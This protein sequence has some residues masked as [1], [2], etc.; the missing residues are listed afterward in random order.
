MPFAFVAALAALAPVT[1]PAPAAPAPLILDRGRVDRAPLVPADSAPAGPPGG[2]TAIEARANGVTIQR[3]LFDHGAVP[4]PVAAAAQRF[5]GQSATGETL[6]A[7]GKAMADAYARSDIAL[8]SV[9]VPRQSFARGEVHILAIEGFIERATFV[10]GETRLLRAYARALAAER[11][12]RRRTL[13]RYVSLM[14]DVPGG[15]IDVQLLRGTK[16]GGVVLQI[17]ATRKHREAA[18][19]FDNQGPSLL[20]DA[21]MRGELHAYSLLRDGDRTDLTGLA[22]PDFHHLLYVAGAHATPLGDEGATITA[23][24][25]YIVT[26]PRHSLIEGHA[27]TFGVTAS[28]PLIRGYRRNLTASIGLDGVDSDAAAFGTSLSSDRT[29]ALRG[30]LGYA[31]SGTKAA[32]TAG[33]TISRGLDILGA[34]GTANATDTVFTKVNGRVTYDRQVAARWFVHLRA[35]GQYSA[36]RLA[37]AERFAVGGADFGRAFDSALLSGDRGA[38]GSAELAWRPKLPTRLAGSEVYGF[39]DGARL[40]IAARYP[41]AAGTFG[42]AS[43]GGGVRLA[44][45]NRAS[46]QIEGA[47]AIDQPYSGY[48]AGWR[49]NIGWRLSLAHH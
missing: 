9:V 17:A 47:S 13:E 38:A 45:G 30:A 49:V 15:K 6:A 37:A 5:V 10:K 32:F 23:S 18:L 31:M 8:Y 3:I 26:R 27:T 33:L 16:P 28:W 24:A 46:I 4:A 34:R 22:S 44:Y 41:Y 20:G 29:R 39:V 40:R 42:L 1:P 43:A 14:R 35:A 36:E 11:P 48:H 2:R 25:G 12:L 19:G 7:L 21:E